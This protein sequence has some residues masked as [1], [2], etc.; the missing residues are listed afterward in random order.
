MRQEV[1]LRLRVS[2]YL[3]FYKKFN[4]ISPYKEYFEKFKFKEAV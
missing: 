1:Q 2:F 4:L 3:F